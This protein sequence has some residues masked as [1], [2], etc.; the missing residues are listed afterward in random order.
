MMPDDALIMLCGAVCGFMLTAGP[1]QYLYM[2][3]MAKMRR[4]LNEASEC[5][6]ETQRRAVTLTTA[7]QKAILNAVEKALKAEPVDASLRYMHAVAQKAVDSVETGHSVM[8]V[9]KWDGDRRGFDV[10]VKVKTAFDPLDH[11]NTAQLN[12]ETPDLQAGAS[13]S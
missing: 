3:D 4:L 11:A 13:E 6:R 12:A 2:V 1:M 5:I 7:K 8:L 10:Y 9:E